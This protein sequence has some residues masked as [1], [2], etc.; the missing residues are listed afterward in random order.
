MSVFFGL[1]TAFANA[2]AVTTQHIAST[3][4]PKASSG[5]RLVAYLLRHPLWLFGWLAMAGSLLFQALALHFG[6]MSLIQ[7]L[8]VTELILALVLRRYWLHQTISGLAWASATLTGAGLG[9][10][11]WAAAPR[12]SLDAVPSAALWT[13]ASLACALGI[14]ALVV[15]ALRGSPARRAGLFASATAIAWALEAAYIK[16]TTDSISAHGVLGAFAHWPLYALVVGGVIGLACEQTALHV[17]PL[18]ISQPF[19]VI[20][21]PLVSVALGVWVYHEHVATGALHHVL[22]TLG[23]L[24]MALGVASL[25]KSAPAT[26][27]ANGHRI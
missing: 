4:D 9:L 15:L 21:D 26:M 6:A 7:P 23:L 27:Q 24:V 2:L 19:I 11:F 8:L 1:A 17:G 20:V 14:V 3:S 16:A 22:S 25:T 5:W 12:T 10:F 18:S 13:R